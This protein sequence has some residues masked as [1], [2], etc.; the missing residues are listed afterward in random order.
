MNELWDSIKYKLASRVGREVEE[1]VIGHADTFRD[2]LE[3]REKV[4]IVPTTKELSNLVLV[5]TFSVRKKERASV[6]QLLLPLTFC[7]SLFFSM[8]LII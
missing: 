7:E 4:I 8:L 2:R 1:S 6:W 5:I 3:E